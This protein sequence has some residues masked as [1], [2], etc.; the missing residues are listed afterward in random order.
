MNIF[1]PKNR[2]SAD[3]QHRLDHPMT[4]ADVQVDIRVRITSLTNSKMEHVGFITNTKR[5]DLILTAQRTG[6]RVGCFE[7]HIGKTHSQTKVLRHHLGER[8][9]PRLVYT[10]AV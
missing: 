6:R 5:S 8:D 3:Y 4:F 2:S 9:A 1:W 7:N 10:V